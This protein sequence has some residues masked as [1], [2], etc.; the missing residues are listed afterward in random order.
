MAPCLSGSYKQRLNTV[1]GRLAVMHSRHPAE[2]SGGSHR[3]SYDARGGNAETL[4][5]LLLGVAP[6]IG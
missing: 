4:Y 6:H 1:L 2:A 3:P 5:S